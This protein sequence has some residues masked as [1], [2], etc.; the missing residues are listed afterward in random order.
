MNVPGIRIARFVRAA[1]SLLLMQ[2]AAAVIAVGLGAWAV[3]A[4][5]DLAAEREQL[6]ARVAELEARRPDA[7]IVPG[8]PAATADGPEPSPLD[9]EVRPPAILAVPI[10]VTESPLETPPDASDPLPPVGTTPDPVVEE[11]PPSTTTP[12]QDCSG[13]NA[14]LPRC[15]PGRWRPR[16]PSVTRP[17]TTRPDTQEPRPQRPVLQRPIQQRPVLDRPT[18]QGP[19]PG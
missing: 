7:A 4:V 12:E 16:D 18:Q 6:R 15:R 5:R 17:P 8:E 10:P 1:R 14:R 11:P 9:Q 2:V 13:V 19:V 3:L